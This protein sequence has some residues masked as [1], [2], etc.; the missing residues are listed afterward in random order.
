MMKKPWE[1]LCLCG[2]R[3]MKQY[4]PNTLERKPVWICKRCYEATE[5]RIAARRSK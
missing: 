5:K 2:R 3:G 4:T 1:Q